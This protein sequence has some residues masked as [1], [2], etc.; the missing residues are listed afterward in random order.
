[1]SVLTLLGC[2][3]L[4]AAATTDISA[5]QF[6]NYS[7]AQGLTQSTV[8]DI[9]EDKQGFIWIATADGL[10][11]FDGYEF[12]QY[13]HNPEDP[14]SLPGKFVRQLYIDS[15]DRL[16]IG[17]DN[18]LAKYHPDS[19]SFRRYTKDNSSLL[20]DK[21]WT[22]TE[23]SD[24]ALWVADESHIYEYQQQSDSFNIVSLAGNQTFP[25]TTI[26]KEELNLLFLG[27]Y[28]HGI[29]ILDK[30]TNDLYALD[31]NNPWGLKLAATAL[32]DVLEIEDHLWL[33]TELGVFVLDDKLQLVKSLSPQSTPSLPGYTVRTLAQGQNG[34]IWIG[35]TEGLTILDPEKNTSL[36]IGQNNDALVSLRSRFIFKLF[37]DS[38]GSIWLGSYS[39]GLHRFNENAAFI[40][41][42]E[43]IPHSNISLS[44]NMVWALSESAD[45]NVWIATQFG[46]LNLFNPNTG[47][48]TYY[49]QDFPHSIWDLAIDHK[50][51]IWLATKVGLFV[52]SIEE[53]TSV[54][55]RQHL[56]KGQLVE[57]VRLTSES[58]WISSTEELISVDISDYS[59][60]KIAIPNKQGQQI[61]PNIVDSDRNVW[62]ITSDGI[63]LY[64]LETKQF[65]QL[66][67]QSDE[68][69]SPFSDANEVVEGKNYFW[70]SSLKHGLYK[71]DKETYQPV[72]HYN[73]SMGLSDNVVLTM[74]LDKQYL[75]A[76]TFKGID[77][78]S[79]SNG[80]IVR[81]ISR[82]QLDYNELN[83]SAGLITRN[84]NI[85]FG[86]MNG[87]HVFRPE[88]LS[89]STQASELQPT[90]TELQIL[91]QQVGLNDIG[92][93]LQKP[94]HLTRS[95]TL[96]NK[97]SPFSFEFAQINPVNPSSINYR[98][99]MQGLSDQ[100]L[101]ADNRIRQASFTNLGFGDYIF[102]VQ[103]RELDGIW[104]EA[105]T[106]KIHIK[107]PLWL[108]RYALIIYALCGFLILSY[109]YNQYQHRKNTQ[110]RVQDS[111]ERLKLTLWSSGDELWDW[112]IPNGEVFRS[113]IWG[114]IDFP[115]DNHRV[116]TELASNIHCSD[117][118]RVRE[119]LNEHLQ[120][121]TE[122]YE[123]TYRVKNFSGKWV[124]LL[125]RGKVVTWS[126]DKKPLRMTGTLKNISHLKEAEEQLRLFK[127]SIETI[128][129]GVFITDTS[130]KI[131][132]VNQAYCH[133][134]GETKQQALASYLS[135]DQYPPAFTEEVRKALKQKGNWSGE[136][137]ST[138]HGHDRYE[139][140]LNI[141]AI[142]DEN[143]NVGHFVG[144]FSDI[145][146]RKQTEKELL[147][148]ANTDTLTGLPN[149]SFFQAS[150]QNLIRRTTSH[151]LLCMDMDNF[152]KIN[153]SMGHQTG[154][155][156]IKQIAA[157]LQ[158]I[159]GTSS[160]CYRLGGDEFS[161]LIENTTD[162][163]RITHLAQSILDDMA[164]SF[165]INR[166]EFVLGAS[167]G[168]AFYPE[169]GK[170]PQELLKN[171]DTAMYFAKNAGGN[172]Y[173]FFS[174]EMNQNAVRQ[175]QIENLIRHGIKEDLFS[176]F[177][178]P[179]VDIASGQLVSMEALVRF[180]HPE[181]GI[182][183]PDQ[184]IPLAEETGQIIDI[185][186]IVLRK[187][188]EQ[189][190]EWVKKGLFTGRVAINI[191]ARQ[192][193]LPDL[194]R[195]I[196]QV[197]KET[198]LSALHL[199]CEITEGTLMQQ[200]E[201]SLQLMQRLR[202]MGIHLALDDFGTG[203]SS[204]AYLKRFP[205]NT[206]KIDKAFI[207][208]IATSSVDR[209]MT[210][211]IITIAHNLGLKVVAEGV[212]E[213]Q[214]LSILRR[215][216]CEMLQGYLYSKP[217][218]A[219]RFT[220]LLVENRHLSKLIK[221]QNL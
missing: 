45:G 79:L 217:L 195:R 124:W 14:S 112:D 172:K 38:K 153:D 62:V 60:E 178:Q 117:I 122:F 107:S 121:Q 125:D 218:N 37:V 52:Y 211:A 56:L 13:H 173:Q 64:N 190:Q 30:N 89:D 191:S 21:I 185:G 202:E 208:D 41:H 80:K 88:R 151:A 165:V 94:I 152:K 69:T 70:I 46:G 203:Y 96:E 101:E 180:E 51:R 123:T 177:Y 65:N 28:G 197:L 214:Q 163:H 10:N 149:R 119:I 63:T 18:G 155:L 181:K 196:E 116:V 206:L 204:L 209:H 201:Q 182:V 160:T 167:L 109:W 8:I 5:L 58:A 198:G 143:G 16:W 129:D 4:T 72:Q 159:T 48:F 199:E 162:V 161:I 68:G 22:I 102:K 7:V 168:I 141:D 219:E 105:A 99:Q 71:L 133:H 27:S 213:E 194:D 17:T 154:D 169:D 29:R 137:E 166:Q 127:R 3:P 73:K 85:L 91:N 24:Q 118:T 130:F 128:S 193:E 1:M 215:Y 77:Q 157:R 171:A 175:L 82:A 67:F 42:Y 84:G 184:F 147:Q 59:I 98:Y 87:F 144:V 134:T 148:L 23:K 36:T 150:H 75:W 207:D 2:Y 126:T 170:T 47:E 66:I 131:V 44:D 132:S 145:T 142:H 188:C 192:F 81:H 200:P 40:K 210:S 78:I 179:K 90:I 106:L 31:G 135:F 53:N 12:K 93:P 140:D 187:A 111:E 189:T 120:G 55:L 108:H 33:A 20:G 216:E 139:I 205:L 146:S 220:R 43:A 49:L 86:G 9:V 100:W 6:D 19:E 34:H 83:E 11:R 115:Q 174:G 74:L 186:E 212:E 113:N 176:V 50:N 138:R 95:L 221:Q 114:I 35:T 183:S 57:N 25:E 164:R 61:K 32:F 136:I 26:I 110:K 76:A 97:A 54:Q 104:S 103:A 158:K 39:G 15:R 92:S 156:L